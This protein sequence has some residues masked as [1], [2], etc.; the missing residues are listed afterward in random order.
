L[1][2]K[3]EKYHR[4]ELDRVCRLNVCRE[5]GAE[6][7]QEIWGA[8]WRYREMLPDFCLFFQASR[9]EKQHT[10]LPTSEIKCLQMAEAAR[11]LRIRRE[12]KR[13]DGAPCE[14][15]RRCALEGV[16]AEGISKAGVWTKGRARVIGVSWPKIG[17]LSW[18]IGKKEA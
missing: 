12:P 2:R 6:G 3:N 17:A 13:Y 15:G 5:Q 18:S 14:G 1:E 16:R 4:V 10:G 8:L 11:L 7:Q 9:K